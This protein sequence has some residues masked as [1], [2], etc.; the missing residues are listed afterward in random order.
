MTVL[1]YRFGNDMSISCSVSEGKLIPWSFI[2]SSWYLGLDEGRHCYIFGHTITLHS[3]LGYSIPVCI[4]YNTWKS[5][6]AL[7]IMNIYSLIFF[8]QSLVPPPCCTDPLIQPASKRSSCGH[9]IIFFCSCFIYC[10]Q[11]LVLRKP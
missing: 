7:R 3:N 1:Y 10:I 11:K 6:I 8:L 2:Y 9:N 4:S 5:C